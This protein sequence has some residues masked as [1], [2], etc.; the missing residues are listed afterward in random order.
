MNDEGSVGGRRRRPEVE[1]GTDGEEKTASACTKV[2]RELG[3]SWTSKVPKA[4]AQYSKKEYR[5]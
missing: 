2:R 4:M 1:C 5:P 3:P